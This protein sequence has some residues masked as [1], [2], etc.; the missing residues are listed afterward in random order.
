MRLRPTLTALAIAG[1]VVALIAGAVLTFVPAHR[2]KVAEV[3]V[4]V[5]VVVL[6]TS[7]TIPVQATLALAPLAALAGL[8]WRDV[9]GWWVAELLYFVAVWLYLGGRADTFRG[10]PEAWYAAALLLRCGGLVWLAVAVVRQ[11]V[12]RPAAA[13]VASDDP[14][15][16]AAEDPDEVAGPIAG[17]PDALVVALG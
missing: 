8:R 7:K 17:R 9:I 12:A 1:W 4:L 10:L 13:P 2:P 5:L 6:L 16:T 15:T 14:A 3:L 11:I